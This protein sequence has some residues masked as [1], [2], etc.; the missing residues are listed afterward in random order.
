[1]LIVVVAIGYFINYIPGEGW[2]NFI[3]KGISYTIIFGIL[4]YSFG[5]HEYERQ[6]FVKPLVSV[7][8]RK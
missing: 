8:K 5:I 3:Y 2:L 4:M 1:V 6:L 7:L